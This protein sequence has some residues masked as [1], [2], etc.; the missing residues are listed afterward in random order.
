MY[1]CVYDQNN[2]LLR[3]MIV[4]LMFSRTQPS[5]AAVPA[6]ATTVL[7]CVAALVAM[8]LAAETWLS[9]WPHCCDH[10]CHR[11]HQGRADSAVLP[12][13][14]RLHHP[15]SIIPASAARWIRC[16]AFTTAEPLAPLHRPDCTVP[17]PQPH[18]RHPVSAAPALPPLL[19]APPP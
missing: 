9:C 11:S 12:P 18:L 2:L 13:L 16:C 19:L 15:A 6:F 10:C 1:L 17:S 14:S 5:S 4:A 7:G 3:R 8:A